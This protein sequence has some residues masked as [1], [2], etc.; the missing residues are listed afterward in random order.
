MT[1]RVTSPDRNHTYTR[2]REQRNGSR[3]TNT[4]PPQ[5]FSLPDSDRASDAN[6]EVGL[7]STNSIS[8]KEQDLLVCNRFGFI[9][10]QGESVSN[11]RN[12]PDSGNNL[13][14]DDKQSRENAVAKMR[15]R[16]KKWLDMI[17]SWDTW[18]LKRFKRVRSRCRKGTLF[19][20]V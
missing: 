10:D 7:R 1:T 12:F 20:L 15:E 17:S 5:Q 4:L 6:S 9:V 13:D 8:E 14:A 19:I 18:I 2:A 16:E 3:S 11:L